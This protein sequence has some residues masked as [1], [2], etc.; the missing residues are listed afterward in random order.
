MSDTDF[1]TWQQDFIATNLLALGYNAWI[2]YLK[3]DR[4]AVVCG[5][6]QPLL[7]SVIPSPT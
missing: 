2:G 4:D 3:G 5:L 1:Q 6:N 7:S